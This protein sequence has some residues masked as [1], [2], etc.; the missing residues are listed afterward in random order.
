[1]HEEMYDITCPTNEGVILVKRLGKHYN[2]T[3]RQNMT[4]LGVS[5]SL[6]DCLLT[7]H[8]WP[9]EYSNWEQLFL[10]ILMDIETCT[11]WYN[12]WLNGELWGLNQGH[13]IPLWLRGG[14]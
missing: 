2:N 13:D 9:K 8:A 6:S 4:T 5:I 10:I 14:N 7:L 11:T 1:M 12:N 3:I